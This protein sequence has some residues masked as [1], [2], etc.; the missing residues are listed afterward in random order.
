MLR[1]EFM[2]WCKA[3]V[4]RSFRRHGAFK[5]NNLFNLKVIAYII[6]SAVQLCA[7]VS[8]W[9]YWTCFVLC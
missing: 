4:S 5:V 7:V 3:A 8:G 2:Y 9:H 6:C 1:F